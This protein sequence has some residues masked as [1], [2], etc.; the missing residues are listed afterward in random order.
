MEVLCRETPDFISPDLWPLNSPD[1][2][3]ADYEICAII[4]R[5]LYQRKI[6]TINELKQWLIEVWCGLEPSTVNMAIDQWRKRLVFMRREDT[7][8]VVFELIDCLDFV[9]FL[10]PSLLCHVLLEFCI[11]E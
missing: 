9:N 7:S 2:N 1:L 4:Q 11:T 6:H 5:R 3:P 10:S 8:N